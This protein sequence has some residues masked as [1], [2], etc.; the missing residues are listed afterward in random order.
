MSV[1]AS[2]ALVSL[3]LP[4]APQGG[5]QENGTAKAGVLGPQER[6]TLRD[7]LAKFNLEDANLAFASDRDRE[8][9]RRKRE[10]AL[11][12]FEED[13]AKAEKKGALG[14]MP[15]LR[16]VFEN[17]FLLKPPTVSLG[18]L[19]ADK[20]EG[21]SGP[22][23]FSFYLPKTYKPQV[24]AR[25]I[26]LLPGST[27]ADNAGT[28]AKPADH[29]AA[30]WEKSALADS[31]IVH[32]P[33]IPAGLEL[34]PAPDY[35]REGGDA[36][37]RRRFDAMWAGFGKTLQ[38]YNVERS[39]VV[40]DCGRNACGFGMRFLTIYPDRFAGAVLRAPSE[41]EEPRPGTT[42]GIRLASLNG[43]P[44]LLLRAE[45]NA[46]AVDALTKRLDE[47]SPGSATVLEV[48]DAYPH[49]GHAAEIEKWILERKREP[50]PKKLVIA[51]NHDQFNRAYWADIDVAD[52]LV[53]AP[54][55]SLPRLECHADRA[56]NRITVKAV[57]IERFTLF[58]NDD[59]VD[60]DKE[61]TV[62]VND[63]AIPEKRTRNFREMRERVITR[64]DWDFLFP[65]VFSTAVPK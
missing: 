63:K 60:L 38:T 41:I 53:A 5:E 35:T 47:E 10:A 32:V 58:L 6:A 51:P 21:N 49:K 46:A 30:T 13:W 17:C 23:D 44:I 40:L 14:S 62:V 4:Q 61:F 25:T 8:K 64:S 36:D 9:A 15:D 43:L 1:L 12:E 55:E 54:I 11:K 42:T 45:A 26:L 18:Q 56:A 34:D 37:E 65:V 16:A 24:P 27:A 22:V 57:G 2:L 50:L 31:S 59:L 33:V 3:L 28:W 52:S 7:K 19:R 29:F 20:T 48:T 39:R